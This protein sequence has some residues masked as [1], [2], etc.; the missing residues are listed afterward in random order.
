[1]LAVAEAVTGQLYLTIFVARLVGLYLRA[2][3]PF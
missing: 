2:R 1:M 3:R